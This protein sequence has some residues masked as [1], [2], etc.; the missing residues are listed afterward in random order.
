MKQTSTCRSVWMINILIW[1]PTKSCSSSQIFSFVVVTEKRILKL[2]GTKK[3]LKRFQFLESCGF[4]WHFISWLTM[5]IT[6]QGSLGKLSRLDILSLSPYLCLF[7]QEFLHSYIF[8]W[9][10]LLF[11]DSFCFSPLKWQWLQSRTLFFLSYTEDS[12]T[13]TWILER[14]C[15]KQ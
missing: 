10:S 2:E 12:E 13:V 11:H 9:L 7:F 8:Q 5:N 6:F 4:L 3:R 1:V 14:T 15:S